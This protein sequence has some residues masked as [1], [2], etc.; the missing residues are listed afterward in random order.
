[1]TAITQERGVRDLGQRGTGG[2]GAG[3]V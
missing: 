1:V 3:G 2:H